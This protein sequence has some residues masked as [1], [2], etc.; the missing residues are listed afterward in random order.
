MN[1]LFGRTLRPS[2]PLYYRAGQF[3]NIR[4]EDG[5]VR[6][7]SMA[8]V[9]RLDQELE[10]HVKR[11]PNGQ[12]SN[13]LCDQVKPCDGVDLQGPNGDCFYDPA[14]RDKKL[15]MIGTGTGLAPLL[16]IVRDALDAGHSDDIYLYHG[17]READGLYLADEVSALD[18]ASANFHFVSCISGDGE[19]MGFRS[20]RADVAAF[21]DHPD[22]Q[23]WGFL[24]AAIRG[25]CMQHAK[26]PW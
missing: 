13:W 2:T 24:S 18:A 23:G 3:I 12:M 1:K 6:S 20:G 9:P 14:L 25:W 10:L 17:S 22:L 16:G 5:V 8:S 19:T 26:R 21:G 4:R 15:L 11:M 7:Y